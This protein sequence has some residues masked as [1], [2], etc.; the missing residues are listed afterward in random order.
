M[1]KK[2]LQASHRHAENDVSASRQDDCRAVYQIGFGGAGAA[3][4]LV[5]RLAVRFC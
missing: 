3:V 1:K 2:K 5:M 4:E